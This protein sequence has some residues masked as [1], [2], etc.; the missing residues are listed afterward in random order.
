MDDVGQPFG[1]LL[2]ASNTECVGMILSRAAFNWVPV[3]APRRNK[4]SW[5]VSASSSTVE[6]ALLTEAGIDPLPTVSTNLSLFL[7]PTI[8]PFT[9][10]L[11]SLDNLGL[12]DMSELATAHG[13]V[14]AE[15][16]QIM[17]NYGKQGENAITLYNY[18]EDSNLL[19]RHLGPR[20]SDLSPHANKHG[21][22]LSVVSCMSSSHPDDYQ[23]LLS[24][25][26]GAAIAAAILPPAPVL[27]QVITT[28]SDQTKEKNNMAV[29]YHTLLNIMICAT[30]DPDSDMLSDLKFPTPTEAFKHVSELATKDERVRALKK[31]AGHQ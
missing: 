4:P 23:T 7:V 28:T 12:E 9:F 20:A 5:A 14:V 11:P 24:R 22:C 27:Q 8:C 17:L 21:P 31:Y 25:L 6:T 13:N 30:Y 19:V 26:G 15:W 2:S 1:L 10:K 3:L 29:G 18:L 16:A